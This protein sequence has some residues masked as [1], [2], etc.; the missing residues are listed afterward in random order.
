MWRQYILVYMNKSPV[1]RNRGAHLVTESRIW[2]RTRT[3]HPQCPHTGPTEYDHSNA[4]P[5]VCW[6]CSCEAPNCEKA[7]A[8]WLKHRTLHINHTYIENCKRPEGKNLNEWCFR[9]RFCTV[10]L[11]WAGDNLGKWFFL[12][13]SCLWRG[14][15]L[16]SALLLYYVCPLSDGKLCHLLQTLKY[17]RRNCRL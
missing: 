13:E 7:P 2:R 17:H 14:I 11:H 4:A 10:S 3:Q 9:P 5:L 1:L 16:S 8:H 12:Y 6:S 15:D